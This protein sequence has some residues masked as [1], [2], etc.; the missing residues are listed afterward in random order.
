MGKSCSIGEEERWGNEI[1]YWLSQGQWDHREGLIPFRKLMIIWIR[2]KELSG[3]AHW[4]WPAAIGKLRWKKRIKQRQH[5]ALNIDYF[6]SMS[7]HLDSAMHLELLSGWW[8]SCKEACNG[9]EQCF[10]WT[11]SSSS[12]GQSKSTYNVWREFYKDSIKC[13]LFKCQVKFQGHI[14][15]HKAV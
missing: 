2:W 5:S 13:H 3:S 7:C 9:K 8:K 14:V 6:N 4:S 1:L 10:I 15:S 11:T 12:R